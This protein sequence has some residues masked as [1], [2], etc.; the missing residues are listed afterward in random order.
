MPSD[1]SDDDMFV[2]GGMSKHVSFY[3]RF[4]TND[5]SA[6][7]SA[8]DDD[9]PPSF[10]VKRPDRGRGR[11]RGRPSKRTRG[12]SKGRGAAVRR[13]SR[14]TSVFDVDADDEDG[15][16]D[17]VIDVDADDEIPVKQYTPDTLNPTDVKA[18]RA[19]ASA[20]L[21]TD[22]ADEERIAAEA[23]QMARQRADRLERE[24]EAE[25]ARQRASS[26]AAMKAVE[27]SQTP[28]QGIILKVRLDNKRVKSMQIRKT[29]RLMK[30]LKPFC[31]RFDI[32]LAHAKLQVDGE[33]VEPGDTPITY[34]LEDNMVVEVVVR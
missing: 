29:D 27:P 8:S 28:V 24:A 5:S 13:P 34:D 2:S 26:L 22:D 18:A 15:E 25:K 14:P 3:S 6:L 33:D 9:P 21:V 1:D 31:D 12:I 4:A 11:G 23:E 17:G 16:P 30:V 32:D 20:R 10:P 7:D 19:L